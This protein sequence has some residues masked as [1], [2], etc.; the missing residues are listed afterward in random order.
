MISYYQLKKIEKKHR[1]TPKLGQNWSKLA[2]NFKKLVKNLYYVHLDQKNIYKR[3]KKTREKKQ[4]HPK[5]W[6]KEQYIYIYNIYIY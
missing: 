2:K 3:Q 6:Q 1:D 4:V 5:I